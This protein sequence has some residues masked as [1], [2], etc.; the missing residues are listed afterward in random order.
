[1]FTFVTFV[2]LKMRACLVA[3]SC[4]TLCDPTT[5]ALQTPLSMGFF[6]QEYRSGLPVLRPGDLPDPGIKPTFPSLQVDSLPLSHR[7][8]SPFEDIM[9]YITL[10]H[11]SFNCGKTVSLIVNRK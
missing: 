10:L 5:V 8:S 1:M 11:H 7:G 2:P 4:P 9:I 6:Q 3:Q